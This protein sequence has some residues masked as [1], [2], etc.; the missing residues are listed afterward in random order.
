MRRQVYRI[1][2]TASAALMILGSS[3]VAA[4]EKAPSR[5]GA[6][7]VEQPETTDYM[8]SRVGT[9]DELSPLAPVGACRV[10]KEGNQW[11]CDLNGQIMVFNPA[12]SQWERK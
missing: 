9:P 4:A 3:G 6:I 8:R 11:L 10:R 1:A 5:A 7:R 2:L 12:A